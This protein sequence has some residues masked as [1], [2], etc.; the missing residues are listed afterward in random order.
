MPLY[1]HLPIVCLA[2]WSRW[3]KSNAT[4]KSK[5]G[6]SKLEIEEL[7]RLCHAELFEVR[8]HQYEKKQKS[9]GEHLD[10]DVEAAPLSPINMLLATFIFLWSYPKRA[11]DQLATDFHC[12]RSKMRII[13]SET[14]K[15][16]DVKLKH[17]REWPTNY[18]NRIASGKFKDSIGAVDAFPIL[19]KNRPQTDTLRRKY[20]YYR[21]RKWAYK[22]QTFVGLNNK[23][24]DITDAYP[25][26]ANADQTVYRNSIV[27]SK[28]DENNRAID[29]RLKED[30]DNE[31]SD[32]QENDGSQED[33]GSDSKEFKKA[34]SSGTRKT[35]KR[36]KKGLADKGYKGLPYLYIPIGKQKGKKMRT[37][38]KQWNR[39]LS[40]IRSIVENMHKRLEDFNIIGT[41]YRGNKKYDEN[42]RQF[43]SVIVR[44][45]AS[46]VNFKLDSA[47]LR[48]R[49][50]R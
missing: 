19:L 24:L 4:L 12:S 27:F 10:L 21:E 34:K 49:K 46:L 44:V 15:I 14:L 45:I 29:L 16:L 40:S 22:V 8:Q 43:L 9:N 50:K 36:K 48:K 18:K 25:Y 2:P 41:D 38:D 33:E 7:E 47:P 17:L 20:W 32:S 26:G 5:T 3:S 30:E 39:E 31:E 37:R 1:F 23:L 28:M 42:E 13:I 35:Q 11:Y 6:F